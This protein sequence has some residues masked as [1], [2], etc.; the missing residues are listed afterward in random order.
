M[1]A[2]TAVEL[3]TLEER[4]SR[5][6]DVEGIWRLFQDYRSHLDQRDFA[7]YSQLFADD[8][9]WM[10]N[11][12]RAKGPAE[13]QALLERTLEVYPDDST[14]TLHLVDNP[15]IDVDGDRATA[16]S[17]WVYIER[18]ENDKPFLSLIGHYDDVL[19]RVDGRWKFQR[20]VAYLD[21]PYE[22]L[23]ASR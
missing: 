15:V 3:A 2:N 13:I 14:R 21:F 9:E 4:L 1:H 8:G 16:Y 20:R 10:G 23:D 11:L 22:A 6:E 18:D 12:G 5:L 17:T 19:T 7:A